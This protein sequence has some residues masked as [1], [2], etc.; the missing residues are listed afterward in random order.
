VYTGCGFK[1]SVTGFTSVVAYWTKH[2][3]PPTLL[4]TNTHTKTTPPLPPTP[5]P[6]QDAR[7]HTHTHTHAPDSNGQDGRGRR[8][9]ICCKNLARDLRLYQLCGVT[10]VTLMLQRCY[11]GVTNGVT[12][13]FQ[14]CYNGVTLELQ[15]C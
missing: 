14:W 1:I 5:T 11:S 9:V 7:A 13:V 3:H 6:T 10:A 15:W 8:G 4:D 2:T 12:G